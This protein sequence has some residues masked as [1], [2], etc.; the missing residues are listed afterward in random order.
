MGESGNPANQDRPD[1]LNKSI[2]GAVPKK[3]PPP[4]VNAYVTSAAA[5]PEVTK[6]SND[7]VVVR[8]DLD[9]GDL[10]LRLRFPLEVVDALCDVLQA[11]KVEGQRIASGLVTAKPGDER[12]VVDVES[13]LRNGRATG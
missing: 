2:P 5:G 6:Y 13:L 8:C 7:G 1:E 10:D 12:Q 11:A 3:V 4:Q 9:S